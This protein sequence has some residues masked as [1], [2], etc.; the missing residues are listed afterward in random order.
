MTAP[1]RTDERTWSDVVSATP[2]DRVGPLERGLADLP[3]VEHTCA[4]SSRQPSGAVMRTAVLVVLGVLLAACG[5]GEDGA[6]DPSAASTTMQR[7][8]PIEIRTSVKIAPTPGAEVIATGEVLEG[9]TLGGSPFCP[10]GT[11]LD[12]HGSTDPEEWLIARTITC[13]GGRVRMDL[14]PEP[15]QGLTQTG[16]WVIVSGTGDFQGLGGKGKM[17]IAYD[18]DPEAPARETYNGTATH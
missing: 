16:A 14:R 3:L 7:A 17:E 8:E 12:S 1:A 11:I 5:Q 9:S 6:S 4:E 2:S 15:P 13:P 10:G 18:S